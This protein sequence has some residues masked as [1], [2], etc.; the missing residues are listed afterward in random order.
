MIE[1]RDLF[2]FVFAFPGVL[3]LGFVFLVGDDF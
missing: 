1:N 3:F 2:K